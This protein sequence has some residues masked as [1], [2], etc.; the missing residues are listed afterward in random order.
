MPPGNRS[1]RLTG[2]KHAL[3]EV[4]H[5]TQDESVT[6]WRAFSLRSKGF[7]LDALADLQRIST[8]IPVKS[9]SR[10]DEKTHW[11]RVVSLK[12]IWVVEDGAG[13]VRS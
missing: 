9:K 10:E 4:L 5:I 13:A 11:Y 3:Y 2:G 7:D 1:F 6:L 8:M 12:S